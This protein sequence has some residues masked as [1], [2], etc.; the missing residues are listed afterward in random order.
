M[1]I[2][3]KVKQILELQSGQ[4]KNGSW[5]KQDFILE[6]EGQF[7]KQVCINM[8]GDKI[9]EFNLNIGES[10]KV[11]FNLESREYNGKWYTDIKAW[12]VEKTS[13]D[14]SS[15]NTVSSSPSTD[16]ISGISFSEDEG[17]FPF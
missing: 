6:T 15:S 3:G 13:G 8:W 17:D 11:F 4:S 10:I 12:K 9:D 2:Q 7:P 16:D 1:E 14:P 5:R